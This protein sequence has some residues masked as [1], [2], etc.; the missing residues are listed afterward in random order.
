MEAL[1]KAEQLLKQSTVEFDAQNYGGALYLAVQSKNQVGTLGQGLLGRDTGAKLAGERVFDQPLPLKLTKNTNLR[2][3]PGLANT[4]RST[5][6]GG[7]VIVGYAYM[8][9]WIRVETEDG[10]TGWVHQA[11]VM[12]R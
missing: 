5:L 1:E 12:A 11:L 9:D 4:V 2:T 3:G 6:H 7:T 8:D 10:Q